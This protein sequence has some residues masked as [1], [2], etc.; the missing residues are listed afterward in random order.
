MGSF[1]N[2]F[3][4]KIILIC[5]PGKRRYIWSALIKA[6]CGKTKK[7]LIGFTFLNIFWINIIR[8]H[9]YSVTGK[10]SGLCAFEHFFFFL[11]LSNKA[12]GSQNIEKTHTFW[13]E[14]ISRG[15]WGLHISSLYWNWRKN[16]WNSSGVAGPSC[17]KADDFSKVWKWWPGHH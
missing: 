17:V 9:K 8:N 16:N 13:V 4:T 11:T 2:S 14:Q 12:T 6:S 1:V 10:N 3:P 15:S 7:Q 5:I